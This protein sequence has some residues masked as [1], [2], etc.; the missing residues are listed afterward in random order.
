M[1]NVVVGFVIALLVAAIMVAAYLAWTTRTL[2][3]KAERVVPPAGSF[4][5]VNGN[6]IHYI[7]RGEGQPIL[8]VHGLGGTLHHLRRP[9]M[10][11]FGD[12]YRLIALDRAGSGYSTR[13]E[14]SAG[15]LQEQARDIAAFIDALKLERP[16]VVGHSLGGAIALATAIDYPDK[17]SGLALISPLTRFDPNL[18][19]QFK[20]LAIT[21]SLKRRLIANTIA[22]PMSVKN[23]PIVLDAVF[24]PQQPPS[25][26]A[27]AGGAMV[28][29]RPQHFYGTSLDLVGSRRDLAD[30][31]ARYGELDMPVGIL[32]GTKDRILDYEKNGVSTAELISGVELELVDGVGH[33]PQ[34]AETDRVVAFVRRIAERAFT[35]ARNNA[36]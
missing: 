21:S 2:A 28:G 31:E 6:Q 33:M 34:Y 7:D 32:F 10:D 13:A 22:V 23:A 1:L 35:L 14:G 12:G 36:S 27:V 17:I 16:L 11:A 20:A 19:P 18:P 25:D 8:M 26:Y 30:Y 29:L 5:T 3:R 4:I 9:L 15:T 24:G